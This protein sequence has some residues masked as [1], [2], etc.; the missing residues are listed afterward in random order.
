MKLLL[1]EDDESLANILLEALVAHHYTVNAAMDGLTAWNL[2]QADRYDLLLLDIMVPKLD[3]ISLCRQIRTAGYQMPILL[4]TAKDSSSDRVLG[5]EAGADDYVVKPFALQELIARIRALLRRSKA[6]ASAILNWDSLLLN[7]ETGEVTYQEKLLHLTPKEYHLLEVFLQNPQRI[8][9]R[10]TLLDRIWAVGESPGE[11][12]VTTQIKGLRQKLKAAGI[13]A[14][15][16]ETV[17][18]M[19]YRLKS[20]PSEKPQP[21]KPKKQQVEAKLQTIVAQMWEPL[22][23]S[24][25]AKLAVIEAAIAAIAEGSLQPQLQQQAQDTAHRLAGTLLT[26]GLSESGQVMQDVETILRVSVIDPNVAT[27]LQQKVEF[28]KQQMQLRELQPG[29]RSQTSL[30]LALESD[31][32]LTQQLQAQSPQWGIHL[33]VIH[34]PEA[35]KTAIAKFSPQA[36]LLN[37]EIVSDLDQGLNLLIQLKQD[38]PHLPILAIASSTNLSTRLQVARLGGCTFL[39]KPLAL[40]AIFQALQKALTPF[41]LSESKILMVDR[42]RQLLQDLQ[43]RLE[44]WDLQITTLTEAAIFWDVLETTQPDLLILDREMPD[45]SGIELCQIVRND[46]QWGQLP[47]VIL[48]SRTDPQMLDRIFSA[49]ADDCIQKPIVGVEFTSRILNRIKR[50]HMRRQLPHLQGMRTEAK[51]NR[52]SIW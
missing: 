8:F 5:L 15:V 36:L 9:S 31:R 39:Q 35:A 16:I 50:T 32:D 13:Q 45:Y 6:T 26:F 49:G 22:Q 37:L 4:L 24:L 46:A 3:G 17:Y 12:A 43:T 30:I 34:Q 44:P 10:S 23:K 42:D 29:N 25:P 1:V 28:L 7:S 20:A 21:E 27:A 33:E 19:G 48:S 52:A 18:G 40:T 11:E 14:E 51:P 41:R 47:I 38:Y 2:V